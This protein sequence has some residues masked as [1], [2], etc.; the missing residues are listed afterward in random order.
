MLKNRTLST[1]GR[2]GEFHYVG[3]VRGGTTITVGT[4]SPWKATI[5]ASWYAA[6]IA[7]FSGE[8]IKI[9][10]ARHNT[11]EGSLGA[12]LHNEYGLYGWM[13]SY[14]GAILVN[15]NFATRGSRSDHIR[16]K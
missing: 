5:D 14:I 8:E 6:M 3:S 7:K 12:W 15:E 1:W 13:T 2:R 4:V 10:T 16:F 11:P 9:G